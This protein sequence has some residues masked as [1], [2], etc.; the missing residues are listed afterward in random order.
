MEG[1]IDME[2]KT[3]TDSSKGNAFGMEGA[4]NMETKTSAATQNPVS[5]C[6]PISGNGRTPPAGR[7]EITLR[8]LSPHPSSLILY[9]LILYHLFTAHTRTPLRGG[10]GASGNIKKINVKLFQ[11]A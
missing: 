7:L 10:G 11:C 1:A 9:T 4:M 5:A 3:S 6:P 2:T 8:R